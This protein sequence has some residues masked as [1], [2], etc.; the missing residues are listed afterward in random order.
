M[1]YE[2]LN[3]Y[4]DK[5]LEEFITKLEEDDNKLYLHWL[6]HSTEEEQ[7]IRNLALYYEM[8]YFYDL[9]M[10]N[11]K[12]WFY[13]LHCGR[14]ISDEDLKK[15]IEANGGELQNLISINGWRFI[16][17][18]S[19]GNKLGYCNYNEKIIFINPS[20]IDKDKMSIVLFHEMIHAYE[21]MLREEEY[22]YYVIIKLYKELSSYIKNID[23]FIDIN[24]SDLYK[25]HSVL[26]LLKSLMKDFIDGN[27]FGTTI[28]YGKLFFDTYDIILYNNEATQAYRDKYYKNYNREFLNIE[29]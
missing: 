2:F 4:I 25:D 10:N 8:M 1:E 29:D 13:F 9:R 26:F 6:E 3:K 28:T 22:D 19:L 7:N 23:S 27:K 15:F 14:N 17:K 5:L 18:G 11:N 16:V 12:E 20:A 24:K 21:Y